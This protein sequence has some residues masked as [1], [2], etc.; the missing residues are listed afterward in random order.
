MKVAMRRVVLL[1]FSITMFS[2]TQQR[3]IVVG[4]AKPIECKMIKWFI[5]ESY[6][7]ADEAIAKV[8][9]KAVRAGANYL[10]LPGAQPKDIEISSLST[11]GEVGTSRTLFQREA[12]GYACKGP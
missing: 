7:S 12:I 9:R 6:H 4:D 2:C 10:Y 8:K 11:G 3:H 5:G 1:L